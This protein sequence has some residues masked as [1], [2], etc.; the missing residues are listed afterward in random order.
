MAQTDFVIGHDHFEDL[1][2][3]DTPIKG[4]FY[5]YDK[6]RR[7]LVKRFVLA[8]RQYVT[9]VCTVTLIGKDG[10]FSPRLEFSIRDENK[11]I[12]E[13]PANGDSESRKIRAR[14]DL[15]ECHDAYWLLFDYVST[16][17]NIEIPRGKFSLISQAD[18]D[19]VEALRKRGA[20]S[21]RSI[22][23]Q[24]SSSSG[25]TLSQ[26]DINE[27]LKRKD[28][29]LEF[30]GALDSHLAEDWW[31]GFFK[32]NKWI[33]GHGL[34][35]EILRCV[36][37]QAHYGGLRLD[38]K[39]DQRGDYLA[40]TRGDLSFTVLVEIKTPDTRLVQGDK[41]IRNGTWSLSKEL[42]DAVAQLQTNVDK[43]NTV[44]SRQYDNIKKL[45]GEGIYTVL[46]KGILVIGRS[47]DL[48]DGSSK[49][50]TFQRF[51]KS[52]HG[53]EILTFDEVYLRAKFIVE[54]REKEP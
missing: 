2:I 25:L 44:G 41:E 30:D 21:L 54:H 39:G 7:T 22:L 31:Q 35:Y 1:E 45:E 20:Q 47:R 52:V 8:E 6:R 29:L 26:D 16:F 18:N 49:H 19:I 10:R 33:F 40:A 27:L 36:Q 13:V 28:R 46:P 38:G 14:V 23:T 42:V 4:F 3:N 5:F 51:R 32:R 43:W 34:N 11:R 17:P 53:I 15:S 12:S 24:L 9:Y 37:D 50:P 48:D